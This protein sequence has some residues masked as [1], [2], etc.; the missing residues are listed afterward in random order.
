MIFLN[1]YIYV[2]R[3]VHSYGDQGQDLNPGPK[4]GSKSDFSPIFTKIRTFM[5]VAIIIIIVANFGKCSG[6]SV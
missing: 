2:L 4:S 6:F 5:D 1:T 3:R